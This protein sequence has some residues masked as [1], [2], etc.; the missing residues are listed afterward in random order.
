[1]TQANEIVEKVTEWFWEAPVEA[2]TKFLDTPRDDLIKYH[3]TLGRGIRNE[4]KLWEID[5]E[6]EVVDGVDE[7]RYHPDAVSMTVIEEVWDRL[8]ASK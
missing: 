8:H 4:F 7:S 3:H 6:P 1:M 5:W 2:Q